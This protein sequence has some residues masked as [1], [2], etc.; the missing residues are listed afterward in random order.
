[1]KVTVFQNVTPYNL[2]MFTDV[3]KKHAAYL[4]RVKESYSTAWKMKVSTFLLNVSKH[5]SDYVPPHP[6]TQ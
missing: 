1:M 4:F 3:L 2:L 6:R 5:L